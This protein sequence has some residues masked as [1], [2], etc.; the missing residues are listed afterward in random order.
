MSPDAVLEVERLHAEILAAFDALV[1]ILSP[2]ATA[3][4]ASVIAINGV[5]N[6][7]YA[8]QL[9]LAGLEL[10]RRPT[11]S[12]HA[13]LNW[14]YGDVVL[15][16]SL[17]TPAHNEEA[18]IVDTVRS[19]LALD[20]PL[21]E[22]VVVN[23]GSSDSTLSR[24]IE[25]FELRTSQRAQRDQLE[26]ARVRAVYLSPKHP[27]LVVV[28][29]ENGGSKADALNA[30]IDA[31][32]M[33]LLATLD[34]DSVLEPDSLMR[35]A[36][37]FIERPEHVVAVGGTVR[38]ANGCAVRGGRVARVA[39]PRTLLARLQV[40]EYLRAF[41][42][43]R[44]GWSRLG[45]LTMVAGAFAV[46]RREAV[47]EAGG[48]RRDT[49][50]EDYELVLRLHRHFRRQRRPYEVAFVPEPVCWTEVPETLSGLMTQRLRWQRGA[51]ETLFDHL[52]MLGNPRYGRIG[53]LAMPNAFLVDLLGPVAETLGYVML[54]LFWALGAL[55]V[56]FMLAFLAM[57]FVF[58][59]FISA[60]S[61]ILEE[62]E[63]K[64]FPR[65]GDLVS[66]GTLAVLENFGYRQ[67]N[68]L[69]RI[70][71]T[72]QYLRGKRGGWGRI[73]RTGLARDASS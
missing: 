29:K 9:M 69:W 59:I 55:D 68:N 43:G 46:F 11:A 33:P 45:A 28:D 13:P 72:W 15:P 25:A 42:M 44:L 14:L 50:G 34:G 19:L 32:R 27:R 10:G 1:P 47:I 4:A 24:L 38:V 12:G 17:I 2:W 7:V 49:V 16:V 41:L 6:A 23:D 31:A 64:R 8:I 53:L 73:I 21:F 63:L 66:L 3:V 48:F 5:Q 71:G 58:G 36:Q 70:A 61:L 62:L 20:Y 52:G 67:L 37:P 65:G 18:G 35:V 40:M 30:G 26:H 54:P 51:L 22:V 60:G 56:A 57:I 39:L